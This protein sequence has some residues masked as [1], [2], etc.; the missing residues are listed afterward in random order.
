MDDG[1]LDVPIRHRF[2][3]PHVAGYHDIQSQ[4]LGAS[5]HSRRLTPHSVVGNR[6]ISVVVSQ[7]TP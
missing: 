2:H 6:I 1:V 4:I 5:R 7:Y 3:L